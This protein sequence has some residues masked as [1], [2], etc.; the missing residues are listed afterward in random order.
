M[1]RQ[2]C[3][4]VILEVGH[5]ENVYY[6]A[7]LTKFFTKAES[8]WVDYLARHPI[9]IPYTTGIKR[10]DKIY[11]DTTFAARKKTHKLFSPKVFYHL[12]LQTSRD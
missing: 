4:R 9:L 7:L 10:L 5:V 11:L 6:H 1:E 3:T 2:F 12:G 8:W